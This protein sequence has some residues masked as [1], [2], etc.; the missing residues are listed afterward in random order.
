MIILAEASQQTDTPKTQQI[1]DLLSELY[2]ANSTLSQLSEDRRVSHAAGLV[3]AAWKTRQ[4]KSTL[5]QC[6]SRPEFVSRL[7]LKL[8]EHRSGNMQTGARTIQQGSAGQAAEPPTPE[9]FLGEHDLNAVF[10]LEFQDID[11]SFWSSID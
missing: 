8:E 4:T 10:E 11:W 2:G 9:S 6:P 7:E 3:V 1:W 5:G